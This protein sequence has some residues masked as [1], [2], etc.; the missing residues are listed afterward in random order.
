MYILVPCVC[1][2]MLFGRTVLTGQQSIQLSA[3]DLFKLNTKNQ[4]EAI[5]SVFAHCVE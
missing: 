3:T 1:A 2:E 4:F 5:F